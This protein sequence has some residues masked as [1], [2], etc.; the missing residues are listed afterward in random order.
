MDEALRRVSSRR[1]EPH[2]GVQ[3]FVVSLVGKVG[4]DGNSWNSK[5]HKNLIATVVEIVVPLSQQC[6]S[7]VV[8][9]ADQ[10]TCLLRVLALTTCLPCN[11][12]CWS[13]QAIFSPFPHP[14][15]HDWLPIPATCK[16]LAVQKGTH[17][18]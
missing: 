5:S 14:L 18:P 13:P 11:D 6:E 16:L 1:S 4:S 3:F 9:L 12:L 7:W 2:E 17:H 8:Q 15:C 10:G